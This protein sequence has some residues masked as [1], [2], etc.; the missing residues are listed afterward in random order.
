MAL[1]EHAIDRGDADAGVRR[2]VADGR[3]PDAALLVRVSIIHS[4]H[5][6]ME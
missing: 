6:L 3:A 1:V 2:E 4:R 5:T